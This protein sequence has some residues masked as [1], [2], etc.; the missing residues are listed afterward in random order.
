MS[1]SRE[2]TTARGA[3]PRVA[4]LLA[5]L[6]L[7]AAG[8]AVWLRLGGEDGLGIGSGFGPA[9]AIRPDASSSLEGG[10]PTAT[11]APSA[12]PAASTT[13]PTTAAPTARDYDYVD[14]RISLDPDAV[15][16]GSVSPEFVSA[17]MDWWPLG[18][19]SW[20][21]ASVLNADLSHPKLRAAAGGLSPWFLRVGGSQADEVLYRFPRIQSPS[22]GGAPNSSNATA[23]AEEEED[24]EEED[25]AI[26][27]ECERRRQKCLTSERWDEVLDFASSVG[28]RVVFTL[29][30]VRHTRVDETKNDHDHNDAHDWDPSNARRLLEYTANSRHS[31]LGTVYGFELGNELRHK[32]KV[33]DVPR[34]VRAYGE[35]RRM[36][37]EVWS[38]ENGREGHP[39]PRLLVPASTGKGET[40]D[41]IARLGPLL[42]AAS[43]HK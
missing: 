30:Y 18:T 39:R 5:S 43:Y 9:T 40:S 37:D 38:T 6:V 20:G 22:G 12:S 25:A 42:D 7:A 31:A 33:T 32:G 21:N 28:A 27:A 1:W 4:L 13:A 11:S 2:P 29:A 15:V 17:T 34:M 10:G 23:T 26:E 36:V 8:T 3:T 19:E 35:L 16:V 14:L 41:L 24:E